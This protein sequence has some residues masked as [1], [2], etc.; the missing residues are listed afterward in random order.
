[1]GKSTGTEVMKTHWKN[2]G[3]IIIDL[4]LKGMPT[5]VNGAR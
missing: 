3:H 4:N 5:T 1:M 2:L